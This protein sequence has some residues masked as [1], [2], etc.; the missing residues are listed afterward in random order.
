MRQTRACETRLPK[1]RS[2]FKRPQGLR[3]LHTPVSK[4]AI[5][6]AAPNSIVERAIASLTNT[7]AERMKTLP[8]PPAEA[9]DYRAWTEEFIKTVVSSDC[10]DRQ[11]IAC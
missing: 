11:L 7:I 3:E 1:V 5:M 6:S 8:G 2:S 9:A 10:K 4:T